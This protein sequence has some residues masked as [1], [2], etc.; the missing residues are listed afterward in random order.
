MFQPM[1]LAL[2]ALSAVKA[3]YTQ[4]NYTSLVDNFIYIEPRATFQQKYYVFNTSDCNLSTS[5][6][7]TLLVYTGNEGPIEGFMANSQFLES[8]AASLDA[9]LVFIEHRYYGTSQPLDTIYYEH[10]SSAQALADFASIITNLQATPKFVV[11][12]GGSYGGMLATW[13]RLKY[14]SVVNAVYAASAPL[15]GGSLQQY[16]SDPELT[17]QLYQVVADAMPVPCQAASKQA[18]SNAIATLITPQGMVEAQALFGICNHSKAENLVAALQASIIQLATSNYPYPTNF[19]LPLPAY[20][21]NA[22]CAQLL[23][24]KDQPAL[25]QLHAFV[26]LAWPKRPE[27]NCLML[28]VKPE[29]YLPGFIQGAWTY[30]RCSEIV[31]PTSISDDNPAFVGCSDWPHNCYNPKAINSYCDYFL[32]TTMVPNA[33]DL[34]Y[35]S[36]AHQLA[37]LTN[38]VF[39]N[40]DLDPWSYGGVKLNTSSLTHP[41]YWMRGAA[42]HLD[43]RLPSREDP[44]DVVATR[45]AVVATLQRWLSEWLEK[46]ADVVRRT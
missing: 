35:G 24:A 45:Q 6:R 39:T 42:H 1:L 2:L 16:T 27:D 36:Y 28:R 25:E 15:Q 26:K 11:A 8:L 38:V 23:A 19:S 10:L 29:A 22:S 20:P 5:S 18:F 21:L 43:L 13:L 44:P 33:L 34:Q 40:G 3:D 46:H 12:S 4:C 30:E 31:L 7:D 17:T 41:S 14:P 32:Q 37:A 9:D